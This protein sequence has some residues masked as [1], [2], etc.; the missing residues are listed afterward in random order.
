MNRNF[1]KKVRPLT[2]FLVFAVCLTACTD[3]QAVLQGK[4]A[5]YNELTEKID[6][7]VAAELGPG[8]P[9]LPPAVSEFASLDPAAKSEEALYM[10]EQMAAALMF[11]LTTDEIIAL[12]GEAVKAYPHPL[13]LNNYAAML[14]DRGREE[15]ALELVL[16]ALRQQPD[17]P[18]L[19]TNAANLYLDLEDFAAAESYAAKALQS[20]GDFGPAYQVMTTVHLHNN[21][22]QLAAETM[23]KSAKHVFNDVSIHHFESFLDAV[24][25]L[26]P[27]EDEYPLHEAFI[28]ELY[29]IAKANVDTASVLEGVDTP[30]NQI[31][32]KPFPVFGSPEHL[33]R[34]Y[35][36]LAD[37]ISKLEQA[38]IQ[39]LSGNST[40]KKDD[41]SDTQQENFWPFEYNQRQIYAYYVLESYYQ[42]KVAQVYARYDRLA[43]QLENERY[44]QFELFSQDHNKRIEAAKDAPAFFQAD[45]DYRS[46]RVNWLKQDISTL[47]S[48]AESLY[49]EAKPIIEEFW[50]KSGGLLKYIVEPDTYRHLHAKRKSFVYESVAEPLYGMEQ[51][52]RIL[53]MELL[54]LN[55]V[56]H[57]M[58]PATP[59]EQEEE[60]TGP[61]VVPDLEERELEEFPEP[62]TIHNIQIGMEKGLFGND[63]SISG[64]TKGYE[65]SIDTMFGVRGWDGN[66]QTN[67]H[68]SY[69]LYGVKAFGQLEWFTNPDMVKQALGKAKVLDDL[70][71][72]F[73]YND[74]KGQYNVRKGAS[75]RIV[76]RGTIEWNETGWSFGGITKVTKHE[77]TVSSMMV[78]VS[79][80]KTSVKYTFFDFY[81]SYDQR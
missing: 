34:S 14:K 17:N 41:S 9:S 75:K 58:N 11:D 54:D 48:E 81:V 39:A 45:F 55:L 25:R 2:F 21:N 40:L 31:S 33:A 76:D 24:S 13:L 18:I 5:E 42:F 29:E 20:Q 80:Q 65:A 64:N 46:K 49:N 72:G 32:L 67:L 60:E 61:E 26:D 1:L 53:G 70:G 74:R 56:K 8:E 68:R 15:E 59:K 10:A 35:R 43:E 30:E 4:V 66:F 71:L 63:V 27:K 57:F 28:D 12:S 3:D 52:S 50:L 73:I 78:G 36:Y 37:E 38:R 23:V 69:T 47:I 51:L 44:Q 7:Y 62:G 79:S 77:R 22:S 6:S 19:L 16:L